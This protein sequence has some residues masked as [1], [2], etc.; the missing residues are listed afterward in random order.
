M[1]LNRRI[2][3][4]QPS[5]TLSISA[6][7]K[8]LARRGM[9]IINF[10]AGEPDFDTPENIKE[11][12]IRAVRGG[13]SKYTAVEG[14]PELREA[15]VKKMSRDYG[16]DYRPDETIATNGGKHAL[17]NALSVLLD[18]EDEVLI[19]SPYWTSYP[20]MVHLVGR[21]PR[22]IETTVDQHFKSTPDQ[23]KRAITERTKIFLFNSPSNP[24]GEIY[25]REELEELVGVLKKS[26]VYILSDDI[27]EQLVFDSA[28]FVSIV[29]LEPE[30]RERTIIVNG[31]SKAYAMT[32]WRMGYA[33]G[34]AHVILAMS[35]FQSQT[36]S[37]ICSIVQ[38]AAVEALLG[39]Q[40]S[41]AHSRERFQQR[42]NLILELV[43]KIPH[44][45][46]NKPEGAF[47]L[48]P[49]ISHYLTTTHPTSLDLAEY[50]MEEAQVAVVPGSAFGAE[51]YIRISYATSQDEIREGMNRITKALA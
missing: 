39:D 21:I 48:F 20:E 30:L 27:Y 32:G 23:L 44:L 15:I 6:K 49:D 5:Q 43:R 28:K 40:S 17:F 12:A 25:S 33:V 13:F 26:G 36:T 46:V 37:N 7:A 9:H 4:I 22:I 2:E 8:E 18:P 41:V 50:L 38:K 16:L 51:G 42:R 11:A 19:Q 35:K 14:I 45:E 31:L 24:T 47:Y 10:A 34:P 29:K 1:N 3:Q